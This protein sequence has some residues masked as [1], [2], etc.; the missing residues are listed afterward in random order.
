MLAWGADASSWGDSLDMAFIS[1]DPNF[2]PP[3]DRHV[4]T[5][6]H[7][8]ETIQNVVWFALKNTN[9]DARVFHDY[10]AL[11]IG[12]NPDIEAE[13]LATI[14]SQLAAV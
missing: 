9:L 14:K 7:N 8:N 10:L 6:W 4:M 3:D 5:T 11:M 12:A 1:T 2:D 13:L